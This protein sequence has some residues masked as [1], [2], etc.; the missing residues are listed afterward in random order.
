MKR[1]TFFIFFVLTAVGVNAQTPS[2]TTKTTG[3]VSHM[4][5]SGGCHTVIIVE[6]KPEII[7]IPQTKLPKKLD[8]EGLI[9]CFNYRRLRSPNPQGC[10]KGHMAELSNISKKK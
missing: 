6:S 1:I 2:D 7:L 8:K 10:V 3:K 5:K 9:I 4:F